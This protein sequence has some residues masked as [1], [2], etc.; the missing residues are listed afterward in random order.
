MFNGEVHYQSY[1][2]VMER[3]K[4]FDVN[5]PIGKDE[6]G[7]YDLYIIELGNP[8]KPTI[9]I[10]S[11]IHGNE[12]HVTQ[13]TLATLEMLR[14]DTH[15][16]RDF[17][18][19]IM[20]NFHI[21]NIPLANPWGVDNIHN[22]E[23]ILTDPA[24]RNYNNVD[25]NRDFL[26][27][28]QDETNIIIE[29]LDKF[30]PFAHID[31][32]MYQSHYGL[33]NGKDMIVYIENNNM[34]YIKNNIK[35]DLEAYTGH[36]IH[37]WDSVANS[38]RMAVNY[39]TWKPNPYT[40]NTLT[41]LTEIERPTRRPEG[42]VVRTF[43]PSDLYDYGNYYTY[44]YLKYAMQYYNDYHVEMIPEI[45]E[46]PDDLESGLFISRN[47]NGLTETITKRRNGRD[48]ISVFM[49][50]NDGYVTTVETETKDI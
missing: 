4:K 39:L 36:P 37:T 29:Q 47:R 48:T 42:H 2:E 17:R 3:V 12:W 33:A 15:P 45:P 11:S 5:Y 31:N 9:F 23:Y 50:N 26:N 22:D 7:Q 8:D 20:E 10:T 25:L 1:D 35:N 43:T 16:D 19:N 28:S 34:N 46:I 41:I 40:P 30:T 38:E 18:N 13:M 21:V 44:L 27:R 49:R 6:S 24:R 32:H 14:D